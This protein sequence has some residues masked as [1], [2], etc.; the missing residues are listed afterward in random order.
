M[1]HTPPEDFIMSIIEI[2]RDNV[3]EYSSYIGDDMCENLSHACYRGLVSLNEDGEMLCGIIWKLV[4]LGR[5]KT[6]N[7][8]IEW[9]VARGS[10]AAKEIFA[11]YTDLVKAENVKKSS[12]VIP[13]NLKGMEKS[14]LKEEGFSVRLT[15]GDDIVVSLKELTQMPFFSAKGALKNVYPIHDMTVKSFR[16]TIQKCVDMGKR[17]VLEDIEN[18]PIAYFD[19]DVSCFVKNSDE[20]SGI[21]LFHM[22]PSGIITVELMAALDQDFSKTLPGM[23]RF[24]VTSCGEK[25][26][27][28]T[29][30]HFSRHNQSSFLL[31]EKLLPRGFGNPVYTGERQE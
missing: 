21:M 3:W 11:A 20:V 13:V 25:Y 24:F 6:V 18:I 8:S 9:F 15:E 31:S 10:D 30:I 17:G 2:T 1:T 23:M 28:E 4:G 27:Q 5:K 29:S 12:F 22:R 16:D 7:S 26:P 14:L 19:T